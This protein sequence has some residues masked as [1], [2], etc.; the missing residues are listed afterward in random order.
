MKSALEIAL[1]KLKKL[2]DRGKEEA[3]EM[4][5]QKYTQAAAS[6][7]NA[8][9]QGKIKAEKIKESINR[10]PEES[11]DA[12]LKAFLAVIVPKMDLENT[13]DILKAIL[14]LKDDAKTQRACQ[15]AEELYHDQHR[16]WQEK[17]TALE[18]KKATSMREKLAA[19]GIKGSALAGF[20]IKQLPQWEAVS[21]RLQ[22]EY[23]EL[24]RDF[25][26]VLLETKE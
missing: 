7:G 9:L 23:Q 21:S 26:A 25:H 15:K 8:F 2:D 12:A 13:S 19:E 16:K 1:E 10:Y 5:Q 11:R 22:E 4:E 17:T 14:L 3:V 24:L 18:Q 20:N 6:L